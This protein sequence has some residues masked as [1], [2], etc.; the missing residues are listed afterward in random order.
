MTRFA[1]GDQVSINPNIACGICS[2]CQAGRT[3]QCRNPIGLGTLRDGFFADY[4]CVPESLVFAAT[5]LALDTAVFIE[6]TACAMH[7][8]ETLQVRPG[9]APS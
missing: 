8:L 4:A 5:G 6:P 2:Y 3:T 7:S 9:R 1:L